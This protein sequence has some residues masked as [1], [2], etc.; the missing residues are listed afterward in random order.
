VSLSV[1]AKLLAIFAVIGVGWGAGRARILGP[2]AAETL[3]ATAFG[4]FVPALL[5]RTT[6]RVSVAKLPWATVAGYYLPTIAVLL[7]VYAWQRLRHPVPP[8]AP[9]VR[10]LS[11]SFSNSVQLGI[12][13][14]TALFGPVGLA[15]HVTLASLQSLVLL[16][17]STVLAEADLAR[18]RTA[19]RPPDGE[20]AP[21]A[22][23]STLATTVR[24]A[25]IH[26]VVLPVLLGLAYNA[27]GWS[28]PG[29]VDDVLAI[30]GQAVIPVSLVTIGL[31]LAAHGIPDSVVH[32]VAQ[33]F[34]KLVVQPALVFLTAYF[35]FGVRGLPLTVAVMLA[36]LPIGS[37][38]LLFAQRYDIL[39]AEVTA[40]IVTSTVAYLAT[41]SLWLLALTHL[42]R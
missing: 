40:A 24:R 36:A 3:G 26:P 2:K 31:T 6:A 33:S 13:V 8:A 19:T 1:L 11:T 34:G 21:A 39:Q 20:A 37:N 5:F 22:V 12:P 4:L 7:L 18:H 41:G 35:L 9:T 32:T 42:P 23:P 14:A 27:T 17:T 29:P 25:V 10:A 15:I 16:T 28:I 30:L 38:V